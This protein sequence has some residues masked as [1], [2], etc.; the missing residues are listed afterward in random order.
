MN[1]QIKLVARQTY[2]V[3]VKTFGFWAMVLSPLLFGALIAGLGWIMTSMAGNETPKLA[4][5]NQPQLQQTLKSAG[6]KA[7]LTSANNVQD[8]KKSLTNG[9]IDGYLLNQNQ[10]FTLITSSDGSAKFDETQIRNAL[11][12]IQLAKRASQLHLSAAQVASLQ[13]PADLTMQ[14]QSKTG[15]KA[16]GDAAQ[17]ANYAVASGAGVLIFIFL[18]FYIGIIAQEIA[19]EKSS[20]IMEI[21]LAATSARTQFMGKMLGVFG[22]AL[23]HLAVYVVVLLAVRQ[24]A[25]D[26][27]VVKMAA[28]IL[29]GVDATFVM[30][31][32]LLV[33][34]GIALYLILGAVVAAL[35]NDQS[36]VQQATQPVIFLSMVGYLLSFMVASQPN[37]VLIKVLSYVPFVSQT[38]M[39]ARLALEYATMTDALIAFGGQ[40]VALAVVFYFGEKIYRRNVLMYSDDN[41]SK[42]LLAMFKR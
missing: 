8:A 9:K 34:M 10:H 6:L 41:I 28:Q 37:N 20:R 3:R 13:E 29:S 7:D 5:V 21:L 40:L 36:Q 16:G 18:T 19:N 1:T 30:M 15:E 26:Q 31:T 11:T 35:V 23:T 39:P 33:L 22:L 14:T 42:Q 24:F 38:L 32:T 12:Q 25:P 17:T 27:A 2:R 4:I